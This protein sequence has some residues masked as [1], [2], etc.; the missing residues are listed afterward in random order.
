MI[1]V[2]MMS[3]FD[4]KEVGVEIPHLADIEN[5]PNPLYLECVAKFSNHNG[6]SWYVIAG[7]D[8]GDDWDLYCYVV[9]PLALEFGFVDLSDILNGGGAMFCTTWKPCKVK[10]LLED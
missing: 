10:D 4:F 2:M 7:K 5:I 3:K 9:S 8:V 1:V 6:W